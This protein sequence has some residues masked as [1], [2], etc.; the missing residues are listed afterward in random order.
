MNGIS[1]HFSSIARLTSSGTARILLN[2]RRN[3][4]DTRLAPQ[5]IAA[6]AQS[7]AVSPAPNTI[8]CP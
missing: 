4:S 1:S 2:P 6:V 3:T 7:N 5:R 8:T